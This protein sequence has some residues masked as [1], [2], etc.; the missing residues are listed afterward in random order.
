MKKTLVALS[1]V[2][3]AVVLLAFTLVACG[4]EEVTATTPVATTPK[5]PVATTPVATQPGNVTTTPTTTPGTSTAIT[6]TTPGTSTA[7]TTTPGTTTPITTATG[8]LT[9]NGEG[10]Y[11]IGSAEDLI[12][13]R[14]EADG[15][16]KAYTAKLT[17]DIDMTGKAWT[18]IYSF[19]G[20]IDGDGHV[21]SGIHLENTD[22]VGNGSGILVDHLEAGGVIKNLTLRDCSLTAVA[23]EL[24]TIARSFVGG[25]AG[26]AD[27]GHFENIKLENVDVSLT[28]VFGEQINVGGICGCAQNNSTV[29]NAISFYGCTL[30]ANSSV[31]AVGTGRAPNCGG[32]VGST[33]G[34]TEDKLDMKDCVNYASIT[35][36]DWTAGLLGSGSAKGDNKIT[37]CANY[38]A[39][40]STGD[41]A[42]SL[43]ASAGNHPM[44]IKDCVASGAITCSKVAAGVCAVN[45]TN[46]TSENNEETATFNA[47]TNE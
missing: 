5:A 41:A 18:P 10:V 4:S 31:Y 20:T 1:L 44:T 3:V 11:E 45:N 2:V 9:P 16:G 30:D 7:I 42:A 29:T 12:A 15:I 47:V 26:F 14:I 32:I 39:I 25:V 38:G 8:S 43:V 21:I 17:A 27:R 24:G 40:S 22:F 35:S 13:F 28:G 37:N 34:S 6:T 46:V 36:S 23:A 19:D 33:D